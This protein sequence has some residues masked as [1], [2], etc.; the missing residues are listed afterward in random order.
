MI[1]SFICVVYLAD[2][3]HISQVEPCKTA[4]EAI[5][6]SERWRDL[7]HKSTAYR[8]NLDC[9]NLEIHSLPLN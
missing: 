9:V 7:G 6:R 2:G 1:T 4:R 5:Q 8:N 3:K